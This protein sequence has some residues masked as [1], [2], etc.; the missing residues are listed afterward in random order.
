M[1]VLF[2]SRYRSVSKLAVLG[3]P[4]TLA[5]FF[6]FFSIV[7]VS[8]M[9]TKLLHIFPLTSNTLQHWLLVIFRLFDAFINLENG[10]PYGYYTYFSDSKNVVK[11]A[12]YIAQ[13]IVADSILVYHPLASAVDTNLF[14]DIGLS[15][16]PR[17]SEITVD[18][19][20]PHFYHHF[21]CW[22][23]PEIKPSY[24]YKS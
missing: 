13:A 14:A 4:M 7:C 15:A 1:H 10:S 23:V 11:T 5:G 9:N 6:L 16:I 18:L 22:K 12:L 21:Y 8:L 17:L 24:S 3:S 19:R 2:S 20:I